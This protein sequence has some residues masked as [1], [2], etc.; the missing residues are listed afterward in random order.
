MG[1]TCGDV[2]GNVGAGSVALNYDATPPAAPVVDARPGNKRVVVRWS[3]RPDAQAEV[4]RFHGVKPIRV[5][6]RGP[7]SSF[8]D[9]GLRNGRRYR[10]LVTLIDQAGN[11]ASGDAAAT[12]TASDLLSPAKG[13]RVHGPPLLEWR[14]VRGATYYNVQLYRGH[15]KVL[16]WWPRVNSVQ[17]KQRWRYG[18]RPHRL[19][20]GAYCWHIWP[21]FGKRSER[22]YGRKLGESCFRVVR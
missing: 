6:Y 7:G 11:R 14:K 8:T 13:A 15:F 2:A 12:P 17:L 10:Y 9:R 1:G 22:D 20:A 21:G 3:A 4:V 19:A 16:S 5:V 18:G